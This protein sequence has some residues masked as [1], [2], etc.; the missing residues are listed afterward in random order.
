MKI[1]SIDTSSKICN[2]CLSEDNKNIDNVSIDNNITH[3]EIL[4]PEID[5][6][7]KKNNMNIN[8]I[9][10]F[11]VVNGPGSFTGIRIGI[12]C[13]KGLAFAKNIPTVETTS[14][15]LLME[16]YYHEVEEKKE[17][18][19]ILAVI[20]ARNNQ[21]YFAIKDNKNIEFYAD[22]VSKVINILKEDKY[23]D[24]NI[25]VVGT[26]KDLVNKYS[27][28]DLRYTYLENTKQEAKYLGELIFKN[29]NYK[30][31]SK[32]LMPNYLKK[33]SAEVKNQ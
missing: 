10:L 21:V 26:G 24:R 33:A 28:N 29:L 32:N 22:D 19:V 8:E 31:E 23:K 11:G 3:S 27:N 9:E 2:I 15:E 20:D 18:D 1:L 4:M 30:I 6:L 16:N 25:Y 13:I 17:T 12:S 7:L 5:N 14:L